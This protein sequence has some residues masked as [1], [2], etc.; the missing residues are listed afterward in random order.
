MNLTRTAM[1]AS[2]LTFFAAVLLLL[3]GVFTFLHFPSQ[4]EPSVTVRDALVS[5]A[6][7]GMPAEQVE[8][9]LAKPLEERLREVAG[10][11]KIVTTVRPGSAILQLTAYD[12]VKTCPDCGSACA[13]SPARPAQRCP[14]ERS[15]RSSTMTS[16]AW[17]W[18]LSRSPRRASR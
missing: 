12:D 1:G 15:G 3:G 17:P 5:V 18:L 16:A 7:A 6:M 4:E 14:Q 10:L 9:L 11:K 8:T 13:P 2:R